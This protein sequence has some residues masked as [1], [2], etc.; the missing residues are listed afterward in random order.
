MVKIVKRTQQH[1]KRFIFAGP[2]LRSIQFQSHN[3]FLFGFHIFVITQAEY[4]ILNRP[5]INSSRKDNV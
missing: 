5:I 4:E 1:I 3:D 2:N